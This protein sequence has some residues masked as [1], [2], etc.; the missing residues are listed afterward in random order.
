MAK[1]KAHGF[2]I[3]TINYVPYSKK[4]MS[5]RVILINRGHGWKVFGKVKP[6][7]EV[8]D[9]FAKKAEQQ[10][11]YLNTH[12]AMAA[13]RQE[14]IKIPLTKRY[15]IARCLELMPDDPDGIWSELNDGYYVKFNLSV[16][17]IAHLCTLYKA[18]KAEKI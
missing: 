18:A 1:I 9:H 12:P 2:E 8:A 14:I 10:Q 13:Y 17:R 7:V 5:D 3:G 6:G 11:K 4:Y 16:D 15:W